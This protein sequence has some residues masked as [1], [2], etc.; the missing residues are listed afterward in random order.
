MSGEFG[1]E[2]IFFQRVLPEGNLL[3]EISGSNRERRGTRGTSIFRVFRV[4]R[5]LK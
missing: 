3:F 4:F 1:R 2:K 5:D